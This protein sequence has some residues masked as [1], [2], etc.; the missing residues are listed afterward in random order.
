MQGNRIHKQKVI[1]IIIL[2]ALSCKVLF[3]IKAKETKTN[4]ILKY[5]HKNNKKIIEQKNYNP[6]VGII[7]KIVGIRDY[8]NPDNPE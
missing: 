5:N 6:E 3:K 1:K 7:T 8:H 4:S 2:K